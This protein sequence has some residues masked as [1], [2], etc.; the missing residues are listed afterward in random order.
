MRELR[1]LAQLGDVP[2]R[3]TGLVRAGDPFEAVGVNDAEADL[4]TVV[5]ASGSAGPIHHRAPAGD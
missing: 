5:E 3:L 2:R 4:A 1:A